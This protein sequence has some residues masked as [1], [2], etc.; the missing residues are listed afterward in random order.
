MQKNGGTHRTSWLNS[1]GQ[2]ISSRDLPL[3]FDPSRVVQVPTGEGYALKLSLPRVIQG[4]GARRCLTLRC[5]ADTWMRLKAAVQ[6]TE[7]CNPGATYAAYLPPTSMPKHRQ[8]TAIMM[9]ECGLR[10]LHDILEAHRC[11]AYAQLDWEPTKHTFVWH[12]LLWHV[13]PEEARN[14]AMAVHARFCEYVLH[15][16]QRME[17]TLCSVALLRAALYSPT[18]ALCVI[19]Q[20][21]DGCPQPINIW[22]CLTRHL[23]PRTAFDRT[24]H[25][26]ATLITRWCSGSNHGMVYFSRCTVPIPGAVCKHPGTVVKTNVKVRAAHSCYLGDIPKCTVLPWNE[27]LMLPWHRRPPIRSWVRKDWYP[28][29]ME[30]GWCV[31]PSILR[32]TALPPAL[33]NAESLM[34]CLLALRPRC[35][36]W[37]E[38]CQVLLALGDLPRAHPTRLTI[39]AFHSS[40]ISLTNAMVQA[41]NYLQESIV[42]GHTECVVCAKHIQTLNKQSR[43]LEKRIQETKCCIKELYC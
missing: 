17:E 15:P 41:I 36:A 39:C 24:G 22:K 8:T 29:L 25:R 37:M 4:A 19:A 30:N 12:V 34:D 3:S 13:Y 11:S 33:Q 9:G 35:A 43:D 1:A 28:L 5:V 10:S 32:G 27:R 7:D 38:Q 16:L 26:G 14:L 42:V 21:R 23:L 40:G 31:F 6:A 18:T 20:T 2:H